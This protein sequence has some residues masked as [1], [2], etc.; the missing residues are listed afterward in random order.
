MNRMASRLF[1]SIVPLMPVVV[2]APVLVLSGGCHDGP[3]YALKHANPY[4]TMRQWK[5]DEAI[6][7]TD[8]KR[9]E[10]LQTLANS[11]YGMPAERQQTWTP[12][13]EQIYENDPSA[14]M[15]RLAILAAGRS[16]DATTIDLVAKGLKDD[17]LKVR[18]EAC[19]ALGERSEERAAQLLASIAG[20]S[21]DQDVRHAAIAA[22]GKHPGEI[23]NNSLKLALQDR[24][25]A[26]QDLVIETLRESTGKD[27]GNDPAEWIAALNGQPSEEPASGSIFR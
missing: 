13:L 8:H 11:M 7:V 23:S 3:M 10:E 25:P 1:Q 14:E 5:A 24:D 17:N 15:R 26:T 6:G 2:L 27:L 16:K 19:R 18:M 12:H 22:L 9:R 20:E 21:Q 4:F